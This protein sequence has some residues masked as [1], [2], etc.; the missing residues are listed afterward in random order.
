MPRSACILMFSLYGL[1]GLSK[2]ANA[3]DTPYPTRPIRYILANGPGSNADLFT[4]LIAQK[5]SDHFGQQ[6]VVDSRPG[7]GGMLGID[8][9]AKSAPDGYT[10]AR[11]NLP[12]LTIAP[13]VYKKMPYD[14][15]RDLVPVSLTDIGQNQIGRAHV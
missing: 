3:A 14:P 9:A 12:A 2:V 7:A 5:L 8:I 11:G 1:F 15:L 4:R 6:V 10:I 13:F